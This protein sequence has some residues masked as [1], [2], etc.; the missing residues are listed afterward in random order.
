MN[1]SPYLDTFFKASAEI[2]VGNSSNCFTV[3]YIKPEYRAEN[4]K[5]GKQLRL[6]AARLFLTVYTAAIFNNAMRLP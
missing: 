5:D 1:A 2:R 6:L 3:V 4:R